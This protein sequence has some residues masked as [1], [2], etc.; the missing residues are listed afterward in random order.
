MSTTSSTTP[1]ARDQVPFDETNPQNCMC[2]LILMKRDGTP[3]DVTSVL[4]EDITKI[5]IRQGHTHPMGVLCYS[6]M[7]LVILFRSVDEMQCAT[8]GAIKAMILSKEAIAIRA[9]APSK[10]LVRAY[11]TAVGGKLCRTQAP[12]WEGEGNHTHLLETPTQVG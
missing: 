5:C 3:F 6:A 1:S 8:H 2:L 7:E 4:E 10:T 11:R 12:P 9:S